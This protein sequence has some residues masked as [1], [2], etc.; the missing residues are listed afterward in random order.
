MASKDAHRDMKKFQKS[1]LFALLLLI[2]V[3]VVL[4]NK[5]TGR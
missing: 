5:C 3:I 1:P 4:F 2:A